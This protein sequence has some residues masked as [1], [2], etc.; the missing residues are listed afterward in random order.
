MYSDGIEIYLYIPVFIKFSD[1][2]CSYVLIGS[3]LIPA[4][5]V[6]TRFLIGSQ[7]NVRRCIHIEIEKDF[8]LYSTPR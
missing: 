5:G 6:L 8:L 7:E 1:F 3:F 2:P 4:K